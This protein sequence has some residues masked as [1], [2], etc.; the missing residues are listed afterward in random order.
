MKG[1]TPAVM[2]SEDSSDERPKKKAKKDPDA[3]K[4]GQNAYMFYVTELRE[5]MKTENTPMKAP[6]LAKFA[7]EKWR[8]MT[9]EEKKVL[10]RSFSLPPCHLPEFFSVEASHL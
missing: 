8:G 4:R 2:S 5:K 10:L 1:Y 9:P 3:P 6:D 7:G